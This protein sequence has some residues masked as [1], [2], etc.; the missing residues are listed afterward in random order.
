MLGAAGERYGGL[1]QGAGQPCHM[2][3]PAQRSLRWGRAPLPRLSPC[4]TLGLC[5]TG[6]SRNRAVPC[7]SSHW[8]CISLH[9]GTLAA[10]A[11]S[12]SCMGPSSVSESAVRP[13]FPL[14][15]W[16]RQGLPSAGLNP[17]AVLS[18]FVPQQ[19]AS[20]LLL[21]E[22]CVP[23]R[24]A[25]LGRRMGWASGARMGRHLVFPAPYPALSGT[26]L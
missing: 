12:K 9:Q 11:R 18:P 15:C 26:E 2:L 1:L 14:P 21:P 23:Q 20:R 5:R 8:L 3:E 10:R 13:L 24:A 7:P 4:P 6:W 22:Q 25:Q 17:R 19:P 16:A